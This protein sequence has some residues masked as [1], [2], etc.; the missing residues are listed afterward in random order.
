MTWMIIA[1]HALTLGG[2]ILSVISRRMLKA[3]LEQALWQ[4]RLIAARVTRTERVI[5]Q[6]APECRDGAHAWSRAVIASESLDMDEFTAT[7]ERLA[8]KLVKDLT[9][10]EKHA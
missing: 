6:T 2:L 3:E 8:E 7:T 10:K 4:N 9:D 1:G 5:V